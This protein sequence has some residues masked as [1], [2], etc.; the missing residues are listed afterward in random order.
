M[1]SLGV[2]SLE[3]L[4]SKKHCCLVLP[5]QLRALA[6]ELLSRCGVLL[7]QLGGC[8]FQL[9]PGGLALLLKLSLRSKP[10]LLQLSC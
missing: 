8:C 9:L 6:L 7:L 1:Q 3:L 4:L 5:P 10:L 2:Q